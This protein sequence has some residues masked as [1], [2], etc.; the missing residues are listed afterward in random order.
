MTRYSIA[1]CDDEEDVRSLFHD[2]VSKAKYDVDVK[3]YSGGDELIKDIDAGAGI[4]ILFLD[5]AMGKNDGIET[6]K[7]L[8]RRIE[9]SGKSMRASRPLIIFV[10]GIPDRM[11]DAFGVKAFDYLLKPVSQAAFESE[12]HR[13]IEELERLDA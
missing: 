6:A 4:D 12:L 8:G 10:T 3:E 9:A 11:G 2:W 5:I 7:E 1:I 13:A